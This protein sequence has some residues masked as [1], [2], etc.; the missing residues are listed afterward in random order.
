MKGIILFLILNTILLSTEIKRIEYR[1]KDISPF[2]LLKEGDNYSQWKLYLSIKRAYAT[3]DFMNITA[4]EK[5]K[6]GGITLVI[7]SQEKVRIKKIKLTLQ[8]KLPSNL[9]FLYLRRGQFYSSEDLGKEKERLTIWLKDFGYLNPKIEFNFKNGVLKSSIVPGKRFKIEKIFLDGKKKRRVFYLKKGDF[10][11]RKHEDKTAEKLKERLRKKGYLRSKVRIEAGDKNGSL[12]IKITQMKGKKFHIRIY[13]YSIPVSIIYPYWEK[14]YS[15]EWAIYEGKTTIRDY[16]MD[17]GIFVGKISGNVEEFENSFEIVY[18]LKNLKKLK[19]KKIIFSGNK[20]LKEPQLKKLIPSSKTL[21]PEF[22]LENIRKGVEAIREKY[23][24]EGFKN[25]IVTWR[26]LEKGVLISINEGKRFLISKISISGNHSINIEKIRKIMVLKEGD[27]FY[28]YSV[29]SAAQR[30]KYLYLDNGFRKTQI[31]SETIFQGDKAEIFLK[32][33][34]GIKPLLSLMYITGKVSKKGKEIIKE[35]LPLENGKPVKTSII[36]QGRIKLES[37]GIFTLLEVK[38]NIWSKERMDVIVRAEQLPSSTYSFGVGWEERGGPRITFDLST[39]NRIIPSLTFSSSIQIGGREKIVGAAAEIPHYLL[40]WDLRTSLIYEKG[41][42]VSYDYQM[43]NI[44]LSLSRR[45]SQ[46]WGQVNLRWSRIELL[47]LRVSQS[48]VDREF[49]PCYLTSLSYIYTMDKRDDPINPT[50]GWFFNIS[51]EKY[52][53]LFGTKIDGLKTYLHYQRLKKMGR[54]DL[55]LG[56]KLGLAKGNLPIRER[57]FAGGGMS[58]RG[59]STDRL[60]PID[61]KTDMP[62]GGKGLILL[63]LEYRLSIYGD[64]ELAFFYDGGEATHVM[65][66]LSHKD[67]QNAVGFGIRYRTP[68]GP[69]RLDLGYNPNPVEGNKTKI[70][71]SIGDII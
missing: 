65:S 56:F 27:P 19:K 25:V 30:I 45:R 63:N 59:A 6:K 34:E 28:P 32:I 10:Y 24:E 40:G 17:K 60:S 3:G 20:F 23:L 2:M 70:F 64:W 37:M 31:S 14:S 21:I 36:D 50:N 58:F 9:T 48:D 67:W 71:L 44:F 15:K 66:D 62:V 47:K 7:E 49:F 35:F 41:D 54:A 8:S 61:K 5:Y 22:K 1:G 57:F 39:R 4:E 43:E 13:G 18:K 55:A 46:F 69:I 16:L 52:F 12:I 51:S 33:E 11:S 53:S 42:M 68:F 26:P 38:E 29:Y